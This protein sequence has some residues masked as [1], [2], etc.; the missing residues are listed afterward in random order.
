VAQA[1]LRLLGGA[2]GQVFISRAAQSQR[3]G[4]LG[5]LA[6]DTLRVLA[7]LGIAPL[8]MF[9]VIA[10]EAFS[11]VFGEQWEVAG[12]QARWLTPFLIAEFLFLPLSA[13]V[14][15]GARQLT[16]LTMRVLLVGLP[17][18]AIQVVAVSSGDPLVAVK[19]FSIAGLLAYLAYGAWLMQRSGVGAGVWLAML[20]RE[21]AKAIPPVAALFGVKMWLG[22]QLPPLA[23]AALGLAA[24]ATWLYFVARKMKG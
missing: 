4:L 2:V 20:A 1:P 18:L 11:L 10:T 6:T 3:S 14:A 23:I 22:S 12:T 9:A 15:I 21:S 5:E 7:R 17:A 19:T 24:A 13:V 8:A 16:A